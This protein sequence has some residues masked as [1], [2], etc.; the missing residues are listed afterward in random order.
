MNCRLPGSALCLFAP[1]VALLATGQAASADDYAFV[2]DLL[3]RRCFA[4]HGALKQK[5][6]LR[7]DT[8]AGMLRGGQSGAAV[9]AGRPADSRIL[10]RVREAD[11]SERMPPVGKPLT[12]EDI[13]L[14]ERWI[15][16]GAPAPADEKPEEDPRQ[17][18]AFVPPVRPPLP[19][20]K[21]E[22]WVRN[23]I[24]A[25]IAARRDQHGLEP[26][27]EA[28]RRELVRRLTIDL[29]GLPP[30]PEELAAFLSDTS[31]DAYP[32][33][34]ERLLASPRHGERWGRHWMDVWRYSDWY[35]RRAV[36]D[37]L[38]SYGQIWR[39]RDWIVRSIN[40]GKTYERMISEM[41]AG[42]EIA[43]E[44]PET[45]VA[46]GF[47]VRNFYRWNYNTWMKDNVEHTGKAFLGLTMNCCQ[48]HDHKYDPITQEEYFK[49]RAIFEPIEVRHD[50]LPGEPD[51]GPYPKYKYGKPYKPITSGLVR[52][53]DEKLDAE[54]FLYTGGEA[55]NVVP[56]KP[57]IPPGVPAA[58]G[59]EPF[60]VEAVPLPPQVSYPGL[61]TFVREEERARQDALV[62]TA[63]KELE[64]LRGTLPTAGDA[65]VVT[66]GLPEK[67]VLQVAAAER[68]LA[69]A[70][71][72][73]S[74]FDACVKSDRARY[75]R[76]S[77]GP[78][79]T[80]AARVLNQQALAGEAAQADC[81]AKLARA[82]WDL[83]KAELA[84]FEAQTKKN[85]TQSSIER[86]RSEVDAA[87]VAR[88]EAAS[89]EADTGERYSSLG[90]R[91]PEQST[92][93]RSALAR[94]VTSPSNPLTARVAVNHIWLR[95]FG[96]ALVE[97]TENFGRNGA[98]P[99]H[100]LLLDWL[101]V[102][103]M[104]SGW[105]RKHLHRLIVS[106]STYRM[107]SRVE[108]SSAARTVDP[109]NRLLWKWGARRVEA[110]VVRDSILSA[111]GELDFAMGGREVDHKDG[112]ENR[113]R[114][115]YFSHHG[116]DKMEFLKLF[117]GANPIGCY[118]RST[119]V[120]PQQALAL[121]NSSLPLIQGRLLAWKLWR[122]VAGD[123]TSTSPGDLVT[124]VERAFERCLSRPAS[125]AELTASLAF[126]ER[127]TA[128]Y[129]KAG[130]AAL[131]PPEES[132]SVPA[133]AAPA[134]RARE[135]FIQAL[136]SHVDFVT[137]R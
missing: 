11:E 59:G 62:A 39:W 97:S 6:S 85:A 119:S 30:R 111:A 31:P 3:K 77:T 10:E 114:S 33:L 96:E 67:Q 106:S 36:P 131:V 22:S 109:K 104:E 17:H 37:V 105:N 117:D 74:A 86:A 127:Q 27:P 128:L 40:D 4:C 16:S 125:D 100:P 76:K 50:R 93:R 9:V 98:R 41:L 135:S 56:G 53:F 38:N 2:K 20:V 103:F 54:T 43:P 52:V 94:W 68:R 15:T 80:T 81:S 124:F 45:V 83:A 137:V 26:A 88:D 18:W 84:F 79:V 65:A 90:P 32:R 61:Q 123:V 14:L 44:D 60:R 133:A 112:L 58:L 7:L 48:C 57:P 122:A 66:G 72:D 107:S 1:L 89:A 115:L 8:V 71:A 73:L 49:F 70:L 46:T 120:R 42:D 12:A 64:V 47:I 75:G 92:G 63:R 136:F 91:Y 134:P 23:P 95:H 5:A 28:S 78:Q 132:G 25:F 130:D 82:E 24:D 129:T 126:L 99:S 34:V 101:A 29:T 113:R 118:R 35:G 110:E 21:G 51:P 121:A 19:D 108:P 116:E 102:E 55:R 13:A 69:S 87:R